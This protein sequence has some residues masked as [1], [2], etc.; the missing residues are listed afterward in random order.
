MSGSP[1]SLEL[2]I[3]RGSVEYLRAKVKADVDL[4]STGVA[5]AI[6]RG[7]ETPTWLPGTWVDTTGSTRVARTTAVVSFDATS[8]PLN[9]YTVK[10]KLT[11]SA[12]APIL[13]AY[14]LTIT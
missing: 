7:D 2:E 14:R 5:L 10:V 12:E 13:H 4:G 9:I 8:Y 3:P 11:D 1:S 6:V